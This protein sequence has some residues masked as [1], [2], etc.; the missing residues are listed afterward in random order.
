MRFK[1]SALVCTQKAAPGRSFHSL[2]LRRRRGRRCVVVPLSSAHSH[3]AKQTTCCNHAHF[4]AGPPSRL[5]CFHGAAVA[6]R[7]EASDGGSSPFRPRVGP[8][9]PPAVGRSPHQQPTFPSDSFSSTLAST[10]KSP[11]VTTDERASD[12]FISNKLYLLPPALYASHQPQA[13]NHV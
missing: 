7:R 10:A 6:A 4:T 13:C 3:I 12:R 2:P 8:T 9:P 5:A 1:L 11:H